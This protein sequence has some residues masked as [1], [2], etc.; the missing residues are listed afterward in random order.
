MTF[1]TVEAMRGIYLLY[2]LTQWMK[3]LPGTLF[4]LSG[5]PMVAAGGPAGPDQG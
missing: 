2:T 3:S 1:D 5:R 4:I